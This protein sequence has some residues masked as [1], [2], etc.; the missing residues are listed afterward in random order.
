HFSRLEPPPSDAPQRVAYDVPSR[1]APAYSIATDPERPTAT[2]ELVH[3]LPPP[4]NDLTVA[5]LRRRLVE[6]LYVS[7]LSARFQEIA[8]E[9]EAPFVS[10][11]AQIARPIRATLAYSL[12]AAVLESGIRAGLSALVAES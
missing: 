3:L 12:Q 2:V 8:R 10:A 1:D 7:L 5:D 6:Q 11:F 9:P 4:D